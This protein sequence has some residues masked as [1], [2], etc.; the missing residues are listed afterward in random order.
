MDPNNHSNNNRRN[1]E[2]R[3]RRLKLNILISV[4]TLFFAFF[5]ILF[6]KSEIQ[7]TTEK[8]ITYTKFIE[9]LKN[10]EIEKVTFKSNMIYIEPKVDAGMKAFAVSY[11]TGYVNDTELVQNMLERY[12]VEFTAEISDSDSGIW[13]FLLTY[14][15]PILGIWALLWVFMRSATKGG[16]LMGGVGKSTAKMYVEKKTG[17]SFSDV[18]GEEE[19]KESLTE[20]VD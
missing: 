14:L 10:D 11:Y 17:V 19:A 7:R 15:L 20:L 1:D 18:A 6:L 9:M 5:L 8:E 4:A 12:K 3:K 2:E 16:G 13:E